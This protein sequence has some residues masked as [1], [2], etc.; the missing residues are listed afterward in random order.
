LAP[1]SIAASEIM[2]KAASGNRRPFRVRWSGMTDSAANKVGVVV[3][4]L[5]I[6][7]NL[8]TPARSLRHAVN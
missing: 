6:S 7:E 1:D 2:I 8:K 4:G 3:T 5:P